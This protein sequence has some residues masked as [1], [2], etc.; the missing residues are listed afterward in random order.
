[1]PAVFLIGDASACIGS[2]AREHHQMERVLNVFSVP[3]LGPLQASR[4][5]GSGRW[6][7]IALCFA[8]SNIAAVSAT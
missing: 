5:K 1:M 4:A 7:L 3:W 6:F 8:R 2:R